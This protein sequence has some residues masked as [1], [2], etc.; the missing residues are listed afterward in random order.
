MDVNFTP[1]NGYA[2]VTFGLVCFTLIIRVVRFIVYWIASILSHI[3]LQYFTYAAFDLCGFLRRQVRVR[4]ITLVIIFLSANAV[5]LAWNLK[6]FQELSVRSASILV[7]NI[8]ILLPGSSTAADV[9]HIPLRT[10]EK[11]HATVGVVTLAQVCVHA[12]LELSKREWDGSMRATAG[13]SVSHCVY[14]IES[15][16][17]YLD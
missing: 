3:I 4:D 13:F 6:S 5:C 8:V 15:S 14:N 12:A 2:L 11:A 1:S 17:I 7:T 10:Y 9:L 16:L